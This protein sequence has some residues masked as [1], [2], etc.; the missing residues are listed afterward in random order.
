MQTIEVQFPEGHPILAHGAP[1]RTSRYAQIDLIS[2]V[3]DATEGRTASGRHA[4]I[5]VSFYDLSIPEAASKTTILS[6]KPGLLRERGVGL[7]LVLRS[8]GHSGV[9]GQSFS[10][11]LETACLAT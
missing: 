10:I 6:F 11:G 1:N 4:D 2:T 8:C 7:A 9:C 5:P 3:G